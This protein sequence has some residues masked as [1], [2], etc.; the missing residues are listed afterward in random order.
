LDL[1]HDAIGTG[2]RCIIEA[3]IK[4]AISCDCAA[5]TNHGDNECRGAKNEEGDLA[6]RSCQERLNTLAAKLVAQR[7]RYFPFG[8]SVRR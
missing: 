8:A 5:H 4:G 1:E 2:K 3:R 6:A 7:H